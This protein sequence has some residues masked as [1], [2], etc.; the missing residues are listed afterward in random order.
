P[1]GY[2]LLVTSSLIA[3]STTFYKKL[4]FDPLKD[5]APVSLIASAP[6]ALLVHPSVPAKSVK[7][8]VALAKRQPGKL[9]AG[10]S[11]SGSIN[12][13]AFEMMRQAA[14]IDVAHIPYKSG[15]AAGQ[16]LMSGEIDM[17]ISGTVQALPIVRAGR[18]RALAVT[19]PKPSSV[20]PGVPTLDSFY[21][22][23]ASANWYGMFAPAATP[24]AIISRLHSEIVAALKTQEIRDFMAG[25]GAEPVGN[26]PQEFAAHLRS[27]ID[28]Y[29]KV[30]KAGNLKID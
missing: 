16:A 15:A 25:E 5:L 1:D 26:T 13:I 30:V 27:E 6:Q 28:R 19:S 11:G 8:L 29:T 2:T 14:G 17:M 3:V 24:P 23:F 20:L 10:S 9:N 22:G 4:T 18:G 7:D 21:P 12:H